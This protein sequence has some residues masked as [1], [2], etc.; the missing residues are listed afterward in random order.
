MLQCKVKYFDKDLPLLEKSPLGWIDLYAGQNIAMR[1]GD[2]MAIPLNVAIELPKGYEAIIAPRSSTFKNY[3]LIM[4]NSIGVIDHSYMGDRDQWH[5]PAYKLSNG[6]TDSITIEGE[7][8]SFIKKGTRICQF[9][10]VPEMDKDEPVE[11][12]WVESLGNDNRGGLG[13]TGI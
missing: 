11:L 4:T 5:F 3:G 2:Y 13:S 10:I 6:K 1:V 9:K 7:K 8:A 12:L